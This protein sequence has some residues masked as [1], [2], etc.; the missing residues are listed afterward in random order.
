MH[1]LYVQ[2]VLC[3][4]WH[5][6]MC[7]RK[8]LDNDSHCHTNLTFRKTERFERPGNRKSP[9]TSN[10][11]RVVCPISQC[12]DFNFSSR[13]Q[14][15]EVVSPLYSRTYVS[16][17]IVNTRLQKGNQGIS[18]SVN[19]YASFAIL[20]KCVYHVSYSCRVSWSLRGI[21]RNPD[22]S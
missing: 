20:F 16:S 2:H 10:D 21:I 1:C 3:L 14:C 9:K 7:S 18:H 6:W 22:Q 12:Q 15:K 11:V 13:V 8:V 4:S 19:I 17:L 5:S